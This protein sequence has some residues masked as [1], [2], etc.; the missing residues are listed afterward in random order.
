M[1]HCSLL[2]SELKA[3]YNVLLSFAATLEGHKVKWLT[4]DQGVKCIVANSRKKSQLQEGA[5]AI[6]E[7]CL[8]H[9][10]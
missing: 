9:S 10:I 5:L 3:I 2:L 6:F 7:V 4:Y 8:S 1:K